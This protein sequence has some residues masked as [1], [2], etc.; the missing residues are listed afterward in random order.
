[1]RDHT[2]LKAFELTRIRE[3][4]KVLNGLIRSL[5]DDSTSAFSLQPKSLNFEDQ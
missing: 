1:M 4:E 2:K 5:R 3:T